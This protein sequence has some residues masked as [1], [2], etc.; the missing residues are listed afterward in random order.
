MN[1][2]E[3]RLR[4]TGLFAALGDAVLEAAGRCF[5]AV[6]VEAGAA[7][8]RE[9]DPENDLFVIDEGT[10]Q[11]FT[12]AQDGSEVVLAKIGAGDF[13]GAGALLPGRPEPR[14]AH[15]RAF[16]RVRLLRAGREGLQRALAPLDGPPPPLAPLERG[17]LPLVRLLRV[18]EAPEHARTERFEPGAVV[19]RQ[20][21]PP[22]RFYVVLAGAAAVFKEEQGGPKLLVRLGAGQCFGELALLRRQPCPATVIA[23]GPLEAMSV[24]GERFL[25][26][27][28]TTPEL[29]AYVETL[30]KGYSLAVRGFAT[31]HAGDYEDIDSNTTVYHIARGLQLVAS[32]VIGRDVYNMAI[33]R[34]LATEPRTIRYEDPAT[35]DRRELAIADGRVVGVTAYGRWPEL[36]D[37]HRMVLDGKAL[38]PWQEEVFRARGSL[39]LEE[40]AHFFEESEAI[41]SC[42]RVDR[43]TLRRAI[44]DGC[45]SAAALGE[46]TGAGTVCGACVPRL[47]DMIGRPDW[48][49]VVCAGVTK[50]T[51]DVRSFRFKPTCGALLPARAGQHA[52][53]QA[54]I[55]D[56]WVQRP[57]TLSSAAGE[58]R[59]H[60][61]TVKREAR[62]VF[63]S[64]LFDRMKGNALIRISPPQ[65]DF[66]ID[67][68]AA[69]TPVVCFVGGIGLTPALAMLRTTAARGG[70]RRLHVDYS[71]PRADKFV[72]LDELRALAAKHP[73]SITVRARATR[74]E[75]HLA[76]AD[77][78]PLAA[79][80][81]QAT[82]F[83]CG[84]AGFQAHVT[85]ILASLGVPPERALVEVF[86]PQGNRP[87]GE[88]AGPAAAG[89]AAAKAPSSIPPGPRPGDTPQVPEI[90]ASQPAS[91]PDE[92]HAYLQRF[93]HEKGAPQAVEAR[94]REVRAEI[95]RTGTYAQTYDELSFGAKLAWRNSARCIGRLFWQ[96]LQVRDMRHLETEEAIFESCCEHLRLA[97]N[98]GNLR[99]VISVFRPA[100][101]GEPG[102]RI[103]SSQL[104]RYAGWKQRDGSWIGDPGNA[105]L[106]RAARKLGWKPRER[107]HF[108]ALPLIIQLPGREPRWFSIPPELVLEVPIAHPEHAWFAEL[109]LRWHALPAVA[110]MLFDC[111][112]VRYTCAPFNGWYMGT[113]VGA[114]NL[115]DEHRYNM[116]PAIARRMGLDTSREGTLWKDR[117]LVELNV[118]VLHSYERAGVK[119]VDH[120]SAA[121]EFMDFARREAAEGR[122]VDARW[123]WIVPPLS[124]ATTPVWSVGWKEKEIKPNYFYQE[125]GWRKVKAKGK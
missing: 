37:V 22:G 57:Y 39:R 86:T 19:M 98:G 75:G 103:W 46:R 4:E 115:S 40:D 105:A 121:D 34:G 78:A 118:A 21:D 27:H 9:G 31:Q 70:S 79:E 125:K 61:I 23:I 36:G 41:C 93:Y 47:R 87:G 63:S 12:S 28:V 108:V 88:A 116:L 82:H 96:G 65:G 100:R 66:A 11:V 55:D 25:R 6:E 3:K 77:V 35:G 14:T 15:V 10:A 69:G 111:G 54:R 51:D 122:R 85:E 81:P 43:G 101:P 92:A 56:R 83:I 13:F 48:T 49:P 62:G 94:W 68:D 113:E 109:G 76:R 64:W 26:L 30:E 60:E 80:L 95:E 7:V 73:G 74:E 2:I 104:I 33:L 42:L 50:A 71:C 99:A 20:G 97:T 8:V 18:E 59:F 119:M 123:S 102:P 32:R 45:A 89:R 117:A 124:P 106:T 53:V 17:P 1:S 91:V 114:R 67:D 58:T 5:E 110:D 38:E 90:D 72:Y 112:G 44:Q 29:R 84:P 120:H 24:A 107:G 52:I 16:S